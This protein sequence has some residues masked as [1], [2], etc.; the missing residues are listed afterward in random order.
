VTVL[1]TGEEHMMSISRFN[2][3]LWRFLLN[4][5]LP[6]RGF[7]A[8]HYSGRGTAPTICLLVTILC[9]SISALAATEICR[10]ET[11]AD[12]AW[13]QNTAYALFRGQFI[14]NPDMMSIFVARTPNNELYLHSNYVTRG[15]AHP[16]K[17]LTNEDNNLVDLT[18]LIKDSN[19]NPADAKYYENLAENHVKYIFDASMV[20]PDGSFSVDVDDIRRAYFSKG[21]GD[22]SEAIGRI[23]NATSDRVVT[24]AREPSKN[25]FVKLP[26]DSTEI[27]AQLRAQTLIVKNINVV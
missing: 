3:S 22:S 1:T 27:L 14:H 17:I 19:P 4:H 13:Y 15:F 16:T 6:P 11:I 24:W 10:N 12:T 18:A 26:V 5:I 2:K 9:S 8:R 7:N 23:P 20:N 21:R 25:F